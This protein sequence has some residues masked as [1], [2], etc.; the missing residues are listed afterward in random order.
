M[1]GRPWTGIEMTEAQEILQ[2][3]TMVNQLTFK[4][5]SSNILLPNFLGKLQGE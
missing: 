1:P 2:L 5:V 4:S 3:G